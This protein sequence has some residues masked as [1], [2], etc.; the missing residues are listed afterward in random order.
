MGGSNIILVNL[1][2]LYYE[3]GLLGLRGWW[4][5]PKITADGFVTKAL[6]KKNAI[7]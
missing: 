4:V 3:Y 2:T 5:K 6:F 1:K 7:T